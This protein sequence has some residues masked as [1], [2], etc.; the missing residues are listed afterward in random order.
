MTDVKSHPFTANQQENR[1]VEV[2]DILT[3]LR[4]SIEAGMERFKKDNDLDQSYVNEIIVP[5]LKDVLENLFT[6]IVSRH[7]LDSSEIKK[8][9]FV[10]HYTGIDN[11]VSMLSRATD[12][13]GKSMLRLYDSVH[14]NDPDEGNY[15]DRNLVH[16]KDHG[17]YPIKKR[18][19]PISHRSFGHTLTRKKT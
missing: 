10:I 1:I 16:S 9:F 5:L 6:P 8:E 11:L 15:F 17:F 18:I 4:G 12:H 13:N 2:E 14:F 7:T 3:R 19:M